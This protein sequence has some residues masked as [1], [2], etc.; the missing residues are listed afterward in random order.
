MT[1]MWGRTRV[2]FV[3]YLTAC[4]LYVEWRG[5]TAAFWIGTKN[6]C[7]HDFVLRR[8]VIRGGYR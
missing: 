8:I 6:S 7:A 3:D 2:W 5:K 1:L 4:L